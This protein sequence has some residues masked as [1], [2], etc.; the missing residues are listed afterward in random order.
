[1]SSLCG[2]KRLPI[3]S[4]DL[5]IVG[6]FKQNLSRFLGQAPTNFPIDFDEA[7]ITDYT[8]TPDRNYMAFAWSVSEQAL[9]AVAAAAIEADFGLFD[10]SATD[11]AVLHEKVQLPALREKYPNHGWQHCQNQVFSSY[12]QTPVGP[13]CVLRTRAQD[14]QP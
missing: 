10:V 14:M 6:E 7:S 2:E 11:G 9:S 8:F 3:L 4:D 13:F 5:R 1:M 12:C